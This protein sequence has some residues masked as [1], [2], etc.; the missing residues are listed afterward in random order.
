MPS[1]AVRI[2]KSASMFPM[3]MRSVDESSTIRICAAIGISPLCV[4]PAEYFMENDGE[5]RCTRGAP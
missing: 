1:L 4:S 3:T 5:A 2:S